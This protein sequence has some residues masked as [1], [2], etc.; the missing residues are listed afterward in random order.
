MNPRL[1]LVYVI[2]LAV[3]LSFIAAMVHTRRARQQELLS[4]QRER[5]GNLQDAI[6]EVRSIAS[7]AVDVDPSAALIISLLNEK[8]RKALL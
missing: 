6:A 4:S 8:E 7:N 1:A 3:V 2:G 5:I